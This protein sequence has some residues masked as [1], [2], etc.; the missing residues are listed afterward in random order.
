M[1]LLLRLFVKTL[2][3][4][5]GKSMPSHSTPFHEHLLRTHTVSYPQK[6]NL[7]AASMPYCFVLLLW[8]SPASTQASAWSA[9]QLS[10]TYPRWGALPACSW[11]RSFLSMI[12]ATGLYTTSEL[13]CHRVTILLHPA[14][15][16]QTSYSRQDTMLHRVRPCSVHSRPVKSRQDARK[17]AR[18]VCAPLPTCI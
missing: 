5:S 18:Q 1:A 2:V 15:P 8:D 10:K 3:F 14:C 16:S 13:H 4:L 17:Q 7:P 12:A 9:A 6:Q 11:K